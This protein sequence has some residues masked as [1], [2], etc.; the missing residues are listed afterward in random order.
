MKPTWITKQPHSKTLP[1]NCS[2]L[3]RIIRYLLSLRG[4]WSDGS[5]EDYLNPKLKNLADPFQIGEMDEAVK[6]LFQAIDN[7][8]NVTLFGDYDVDGITSVTLLYRVLSEYGLS[9]HIVIPLRAKEG[10]GLS[11]AAVDRCLEENAQTSLLVAMDCGTSSVEEIQKLRDAGVDVLVIDHHESNTIE[12]PNCNAIV[13]PKAKFTPNSE[14]DFAYLCAAGVVFKVCHALLK[15]R[16]LESLSLKDLLD[17]VAIATVADIV[18]LVRENRILVRHGLKALG[19]TQKLGL[20]ALKE[21]AGVGEFPESEDI[22]FKIAP[23]INAAGRMDAPKEA[24][25][26]MLTDSVQTAEYLV[27]RLN[28]YNQERQSFEKEI[29]KEAVEMVKTESLDEQA[30]IILGKSGWHPGVVGIVAARIMRRYFKPCFIIAFDEEGNGKGSGRSL[31]GLSLVDAIDAGREYIE[32]GGGHHAAAGIS[33]KMENIAKFSQSVNDYFLT[34]TSEKQRAP[35]IEIDVEVS[36]E[37]LTFDFLSS[38][39]QLKPFGSGNPRPVFMS[40]GVTNSRSPMELKNQHLKL[41]LAQDGE[42]RDAIFFGGGVKPLPPE[43]WDICYTVGKNV[44]RGRTNLQ[45]TI[46]HVRSAV[47]E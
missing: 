22:G 35:Y 3:P 46:Q 39:D 30:C 47:V 2:H 4:E 34:E 8:E 45:M 25:E 36:F 11:E 38:Y 44:F 40:K 13:N 26:V 5:L 28:R 19:V 29:L 43:P 16:M 6:R 1:S 15:T 37:E 10:Y 42:Q 33:I 17:F 18:P 32:A 31:N 21:T 14:G 41:F 7:D 20:I 23:R 9:P 27:A 12:R 24:L